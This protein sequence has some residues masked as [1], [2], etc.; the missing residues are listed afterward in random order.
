MELQEAIIA[1]RKKFDEGPPIW[2]M[3]DN[4]AIEIIINAIESGVAIE[5]GV[6][7]NAPDDAVF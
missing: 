7:K 2:G 3:S 4:E 6:E 1:Y 5:E